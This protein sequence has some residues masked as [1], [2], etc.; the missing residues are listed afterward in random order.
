[1]RG[2]PV[3]DFHTAEIRNQPARNGRGRN[4]ILRSWFART[5]Y[6][7]RWKTLPDQE[8]RRASQLIS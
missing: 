6:Y 2:F 3:R 1:M 7:G 5:D 4:R 8:N